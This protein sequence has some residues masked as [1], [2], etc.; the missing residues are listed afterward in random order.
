MFARCL[1]G[2]KFFF[3]ALD[4]GLP[5]SKIIA[6]GLLPHLHLSQSLNST[7]SSISLQNFVTSCQELPSFYPFLSIDQEWLPLILP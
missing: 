6:V 3:V 4:T 5:P 1:F 7:I 2:T